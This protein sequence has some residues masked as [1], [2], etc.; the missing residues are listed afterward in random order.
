MSTTT[1][2]HEQVVIVGH[3]GL[4]LPLS[5]AD[6]CALLPARGSRALDG[7]G[8]E[9]LAHLPE[10]WETL[11]VIHP[12]IFEDVPTTPIRRDEKDYDAE[13]APW[14]VCVN[15]TAAPEDFRKAIR[16]LLHTLDT[17]GARALHH[18]NWVGSGA[19][20]TGRMRPL[21]LTRT[22]SGRI[23]AC[24]IPANASQFYYPIRSWDEAAWRQSV[25]EAA[26][27]TVCSVEGVY[28]LEALRRGLHACQV[29]SLHVRF[30]FHL[31]N[32]FEAP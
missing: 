7:D 9:G 10:G 32:G 24:V 15:Q 3:T 31:L 25:D 28:D 13:G 20:M 5:F 29:G 11:F 2:G 14:R 30:I 17:Q 1:A 26:K 23:L 18:T 27:D 16:K 4:M 19:F 21:W 6:Y 22:V 8:I 12:G